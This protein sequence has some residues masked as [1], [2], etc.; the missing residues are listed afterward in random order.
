MR[1]IFLAVAIL[2][3][4]VG[5]VWSAPRVALESDANEAGPYNVSVSTYTP[6]TLISAADSALL[7]IMLYHGDADN[8]WVSTCTAPAA[9][10]I[11]PLGTSTYMNLEI[12]AWKGPIYGKADGSSAI[13]IYFW[14]TKR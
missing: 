14:K 1:K 2:F 12:N 3:L 9:T 11:L 7:S 6:Y 8:I 13:T 4:S 5:V 10:N